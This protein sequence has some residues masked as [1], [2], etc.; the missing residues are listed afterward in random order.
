M[1]ILGNFIVS[2]ANC[3][4]IDALY[5][6]TI[7]RLKIKLNVGRPIT[8]PRLINADKA[9]D[10]EEI[11][12]YNRNRG[13]ISNIPVNKRNRKNPKMGRPFRLSKEDYAGRSVIERFFSWIEAFRK[14]YP[15]CERLEQSYL[16]LTLLACSLILWRV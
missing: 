12:N 15:R 14:I 3:K 10:S 8:R 13:I 5:I 11:R 7:S 1:K 4:F 9:Y 16:G 2:G 6:Q